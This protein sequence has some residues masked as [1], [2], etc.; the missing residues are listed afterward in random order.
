[1]IPSLDLV[2]RHPALNLHR[3]GDGHET[4]L[5]WPIDIYLVISYYSTTQHHHDHDHDHVHSLVGNGHL[6]LP[7]NW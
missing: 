4:G 7:R 5:H 2:V 3:L 6:G 1:M